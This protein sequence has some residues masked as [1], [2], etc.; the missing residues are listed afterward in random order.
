LESFRDLGQLKRAVNH[1]ELALNHCFYVVNVKNSN[2]IIGEY[3]LVC[4]VK[5]QVVNRLDRLLIF[6]CE[7]GAQTLS[8]KEKRIEKNLWWNHFALFSEKLQIELMAFRLFLAFGK[9]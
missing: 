1:R 7:T 4:K 5:H 6:S 8:Y 3:A 2:L 9:L